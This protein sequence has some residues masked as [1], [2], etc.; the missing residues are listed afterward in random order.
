MPP[1]PDNVGVLESDGKVGIGVE[2]KSDDHIR[3]P[4][5]F[6]K[7]VSKSVLPRL[8]GDSDNSDRFLKY[9]RKYPERRFLAT[10]RSYQSRDYLVN[11]QGFDVV[12]K[13]IFNAGR[14]FHVFEPLMVQVLSYSAELVVVQ[15]VKF[16][17]IE[18]ERR[19]AIIFNKIRNEVSLL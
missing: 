9:I 17:D 13:C 10:F 11:I 2:F 7:H 4:D 14:M 5:D 6:V 18:Y 12:A 19:I 16:L 1:C 8:I 15:H 3:Y